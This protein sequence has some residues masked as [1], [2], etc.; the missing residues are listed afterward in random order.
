[1]R[2]I[3]QLIALCATA[4]LAACTSGTASLPPDAA[5]IVACGNGV[6]EAGEVCDDGNAATGDGCDLN[7]MATGCG[8][9][10]MTGAEACDDGN[11]VSGDGCDNNCTITEC[12]N[13]VLTAGE[14]CDDGN[15]VD[16][17]GCDRNCTVTGCGNGV[18]TVDEVCDDGNPINGDGC[19]NNC[20]ITECGNGV[21]TAGEGCDDGNTADGDGC[22]SN[23]TVTACGNGVVTAG[24]GCDDGNTTDGDGCEHNCTLSVCG[25][26][27]PAGGEGC[28]DGNTTDGDGCDSNCEPTGCGNGVV[29]SGEVCDDGNLTDWDGCNSDCTTSALAYV[30]ASNTSS[31]SLFGRSV[32]VSGD[33]STLAVAASAENSAAT[34]IDGNQADHSAP[35]AGAV[36]VFARSGTAWVQQA[37]IKA[38]NTGPGNEFGWSIALSADGSTLAVGAWLE[39]SAATGIDGNQADTSAEEAGAVYVF[40]RNGTTWSQQAYVKA[41]NT[42]AA[43]FFGW[44]VALSGD[45][46]TLAV[47]AI[48]EDSATTGID[49]EQADNSAES[50]GAVYVFTRNGTTWSQQAYVKASNTGASDHLGANDFFG[51]SVALSGDGSMLAVG[52]ISEDSAATGIDGNQADNSAPGAGAVYVFSRTGMTWSQQAYVKASNAGTHDGF[53]SSVAMSAD[54]TTLAVGAFGEGSAATGVDGDQT[55]EVAFDAGAAYVFVRSGASWSQQAYVKASNTDSQDRFGWRIALSSDG[56]TLAVSGRDERSAATGINGDQAD[57]SAFNAGAVY[58]FTRSGLTWNQHAYVKASNTD[59]GDWFGWS[60]ALSG[61]GSTLVVGALLEASPAT[62]V[63]GN[64]SGNSAQGAGAVYVFR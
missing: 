61:D 6:V 19:D 9:G 16:G 46:S 17:D 29:T 20:T 62:G 25:N 60:L 35:G 54:G 51:W 4:V 15:T 2:M 41:S 22:D 21:P 55:D 64:Q 42:D 28:D 34:G 8:N 47:A 59:T 7:C 39:D 14:G 18:V 3:A 26:G 56:S 40:T 23:C 38:S 53:G 30:K 1:M 63:G 27:I 58:V 36:Y 43:D 31:F 44:T 5:P 37:Y 49:G 32:A 48:G 50:A 52:A 45:G 13:G 57:N 11:A 33:G 12:S 10:V 24:E